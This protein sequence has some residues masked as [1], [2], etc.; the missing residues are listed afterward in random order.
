MSVSEFGLIQRY[1]SKQITNATINQLG[2]G[3]DCALM[4]IPT[5]EQ[6][7]LT[8]DT[9]VEGVHFFPEANPQQLGHKILAVN[10]SDLAAM[11]AKPVSITLALTLPEVNEQWLAAFSKGLSALAKQFSVDLIG[12]DT[13]SGS[14]TLTIQA[15][16]LVPQGKAL[17]R[18][19]AKVGDLIFVTG[20]LGDAGLGL[21]IEN[22]Y[23]C[24]SPENALKRFHLPMPRVQEGLAIREYANACI[25]LS[26][27]IAS[28][29]KHIL[30]ESGVGARLDWD[31]VPV[32]YEVSAYIK[33]TDNWSLPLSAGD[34][35]ELCF[36]ISPDKVEEINIACTQVGVIE[37]E[38][39]LRIQ[40]FGVTE[41]LRATGF[42]HFS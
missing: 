28:D 1:F 19:S 31:K 15:I 17:L 42:E 36:T 32:S 25:D 2:V 14:L 3:D 40:R 11:G 30:D 7:A 21:K 18:S 29:L 24:S 9:M 22:G 27:G 23:P 12:G 20:C 5:G 16:G 6:M 10:L 41:E 33:E 26:D 13:T 34:D 37:A 4:S 8:T 35:Y 38:A 39:G